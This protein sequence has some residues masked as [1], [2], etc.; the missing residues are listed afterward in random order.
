MAG[1][2]GF[3]IFIVSGP[4]GC[5]KSTLV[6]KLLQLPRMRLSV[7][8]TTRPPRP[9]ERE[10]EWYG[11]VD[12]RSFQ[13]MRDRGDFIEWAEVFGNFYGTPN[14]ELEAARAAG[15]DVVLEIDVQGADQ[16]KKKIGPTAIAIFIAPP[17]RD[18]LE[19]RLRG[20]GKDSE[21]AI[22]RRLETA[23]REMQRWQDYDYIVVNDDLASASAEVIAIANAVRDGRRFATAGREQNAGRIRKILATFGGN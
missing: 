11:F 15:E 16:V 14:S 23:A 12:A 10:G 21:A 13:A 8:V 7:S 6:E 5:G 22:A 1:A 9:G 19:A 18:A 2:D 4:S 17:S 3:R 20:R